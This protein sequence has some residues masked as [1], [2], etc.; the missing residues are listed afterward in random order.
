MHVALRPDLNVPTECARYIR[1]QRFAQVA[2]ATEVTRK[3]SAAIEAEFNEALPHLPAHVESILG[4]GC[5]MAGFEVMLAK[6]YG[7]RLE[8]LDG[9]EANL[10]AAVQH[11]SGVGGWNE[12]LKPYNSRAHTEMLA[13]ANGVRI[14][15]WHAVGTR[16]TLRAD[17]IV[18]LWSL[19]FHYPLTTYRMS[20][21]CLMD[22]RK[23]KERARGLVISSGVKHDRCL[24]RMNG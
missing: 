5:G 4:I 11:E 16:Q 7:A 22:L 24:F 12:K 3:Y 1:W 14:D 21:L 15:R 6:H 18:S 8:L 10:N 9:D 13:E 20:G 23:G 17:L 2:D 19:G